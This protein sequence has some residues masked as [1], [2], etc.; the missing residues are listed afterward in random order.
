MKKIMSTITGVGLA[1][2]AF[3]E[4]P[5]VTYI[6]VN[7]DASRLVTVNY[8]LAG[9]AAVTTMSVETNAGDNVWVPIGD[10]NISHVAG[11]VNRKVAA[12]DHSFT[13]T[14]NLSWPTKGSRTATSASASRSGR[15]T[16]RRITWR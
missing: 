16:I 10:A 8:T 7:Q 12:G 4:A 14:P 3:A 5:S 6:E 9:E 15:W 1:A 11:D 2:F 13:W